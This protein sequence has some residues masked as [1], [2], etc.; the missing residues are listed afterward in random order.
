MD[1]MQQHL[2][3]G[4]RPEECQ[5][6]IEKNPR[7]TREER[8]PVEKLFSQVLDKE[9]LEIPKIILFCDIHNLLYVSMPELIV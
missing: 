6:I 5:L 8:F 3:H 2:A 1:T 7:S 4:R 9:E